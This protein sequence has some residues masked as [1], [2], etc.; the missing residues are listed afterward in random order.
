M[1]KRRNYLLGEELIRRGYCTLEQI[2]R[3]LSLQSETKETLGAV[4]I[5]L[6]FISEHQL[7]ETLSDQ[8]NLPYIDPTTSSVD[9]SVL[10]RVSAKVAKHYHIFPIKF[11]NN[12]VLIVSNDPQQG[13][14]IEEL[15]AMLGTEIYLALAERRKI[16]RAIQRYYGIGA[17]VLEDLVRDDKARG[18]TAQTE[19]T[20]LV[21]DVTA[22]EEEGTVRDLVNQLLLDAQKKRASD[23]HIEPFPDHLSIRYRVDG[24]LMDANVPESIVK[25]HANIISRIKIMANLDVSEKRLPQDGRIKIKIGSE[26]LDL[27]IS[28]LPSAFGE[29][30][31]IRILTP[32]RLLEMDQIQFSEQNTL[33]VKQILTRN[34]GI[35]LMTGPTGSG[36]TTTLYACLK[37]LNGKGKKIIT[38]EDPVEYQISG[39]VQMQVHPKIGLTFA[40][41]LRHMLRHDPDVMM[42]GEIR[43]IETAEIAIRSAMTGHLVFSTLH[44][45][46]ACGAVARLM[47]M[48]I[49]SFLVASSLE[50]VISQRLVRLICSSCKE[51]DSN[52]PHVFT[53]SP[54]ASGMT[55]YKGKGCEQC[56]GSGYYGRLAIHE[57]LPMNDHL[58]DCIS[59]QMAL[60]KF[61]EE[62]VKQGMIRLVD[63]GLQKVKAGLTTIS[64]VMQFG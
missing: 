62:A 31:V 42:V 43:D 52:P 24:V 8:L 13:E 46:D 51:V 48:E 37:E 23:I 32:A 49:E 5:R 20:T 3:S 30:L 54:L 17:S 19:H 41:G 38:V 60:T 39:V 7:L 35:L 36:K 18:K 64:E 63:D 56:G 59:R 28:I 61:R 47:D 34:S 22:T 1:G 40:S 26:E 2:D 12:G 33:L 15:K 6:G 4:L 21:E 44:T 14:M 9:K 25:F 29:S 58:R 55:S 27:R 16:D 10:S 57:V 50:C 53:N 45:N 11:Q